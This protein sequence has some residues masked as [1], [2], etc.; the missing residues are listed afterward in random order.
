MVTI[1]VRTNKQTNEQ[2][3]GQPGKHNAFAKT[4][5]WRRHNKYQWF[6]SVHVVL[7]LESQ[8]IGRN[9]PSNRRPVVDNKRKMP[10]HK[11]RSVLCISFSALTLLAVR[12]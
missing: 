7:S 12:L 10:G 2:T 1:F 6:L 3:D 8:L 9:A 11:L 4:V 5:G